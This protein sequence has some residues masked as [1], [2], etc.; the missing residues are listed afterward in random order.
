MSHLQACLGPLLG[1]FE[2]FLGSIWIL[3]LFR[4][5]PLLGSF[6]PFLGSI[7]ILRLFRL[8]PLLGS[9]GS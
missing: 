7:W 3:R 4:L 9:F 1:S 6:E 5:G 8:G 2:P